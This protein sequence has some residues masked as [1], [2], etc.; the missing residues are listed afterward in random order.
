MIY[1]RPRL[2]R[3]KV[4]KAETRAYGQDVL[5][6]QMAMRAKRKLHMSKLKWRRRI[7]LQKWATAPAAPLS[8]QWMQPLACA[9]P[10]LWAAD[11]SQLSSNRRR[12]HMG[13][14]V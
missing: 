10:T 6:K 11:G 2:L 13:Q 12:C 7:Q 3:P 9:A 4:C 14:I 8:C 1:G 5:Q